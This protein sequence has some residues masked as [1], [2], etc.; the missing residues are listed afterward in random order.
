M[1]FP[2]NSCSTRRKTNTANEGDAIICA[3]AETFTLG[4]KAGVRLDAVS[5]SMR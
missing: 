2:R 4:V 1:F 3:L 5:R